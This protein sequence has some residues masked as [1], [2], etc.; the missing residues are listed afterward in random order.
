VLLKQQ[1]QGC[2]NTNYKLKIEMKILAQMLLHQAWARLGLCN[3]RE[4][5]R[6]VEGHPVAN[7]FPFLIKTQSTAL[8]SAVR[9]KGQKSLAGASFLLLLAGPKSCPN[10]SS[11]FPLLWPTSVRLRIWCKFINNKM[12]TNFLRL[13]L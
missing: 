2:F 3:R 6:E 11:I 10:I 13:R 4:R 8:I 9:S 1:V 12:L 7:R 5:Q